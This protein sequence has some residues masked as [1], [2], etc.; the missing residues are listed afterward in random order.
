[1]K[2]TLAWSWNLLIFD[3]SFSFFVIQFKFLYIRDLD[4]IDTTQQLKFFYL[5]G[6]TLDR[7]EKI[8]TKQSQPEAVDS[9]SQGV[10]QVETGHASEFVTEG[11]EAVVFTHQLCSVLVKDF[12]GVVEAKYPVILCSTCT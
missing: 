8:S 7:I 11:E 5:W 3:K 9:L 2:R 6:V 1:M 12:P 10:T 4:E